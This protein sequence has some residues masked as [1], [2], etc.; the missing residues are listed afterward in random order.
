MK[1]QLTIL[2]GLLPIAAAAQTGS[3][4]AFRFWFQRDAAC[5][6]CAQMPPP[7][8]RKAFLEGAGIDVMF[9]GY[10]QATGKHWLNLKVENYVVT[11]TYELDGATHSDKL[12]AAGDA[13][14][15]VF[16]PYAPADVNK[17]RV[18]SIT[19]T[20]TYSTGPVTKKV[21]SP[22]AFKLY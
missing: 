8:T 1:I 12:F 10:D 6:A 20:A 5:V 9:N 17:A 18:V 7:G 21:S 19:V 2:A 15:V 11:Y 4:E 13:A 3:S 14:S 22:V 16:K